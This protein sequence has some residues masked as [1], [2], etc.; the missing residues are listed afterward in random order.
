MGP[1]LQRHCGGENGVVD[2]RGAITDE[3]ERTALKVAAET[4]PGVEGV[5]DHLVWVEPTTGLVLPATGEGKEQPSRFE[6]I[7][8]VTP[9]EP[10]GQEG[11]HKRLVCDRG[12][13]LG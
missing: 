4:V 7:R 3:R 6:Q 10:S 1:A 8:T 2:L 5:H 11:P 13:P 12:D 9:V